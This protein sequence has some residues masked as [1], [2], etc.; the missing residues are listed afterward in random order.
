MVLFRASASAFGIVTLA[1]VVAGAR[2]AGVFPRDAQRQA[3][4]S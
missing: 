4:A 2:R 3:F 1:N